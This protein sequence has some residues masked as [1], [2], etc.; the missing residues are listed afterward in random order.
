MLSPNL[1]VQRMLHYGEIREE[2]G[3][4][5]RAKLKRRENVMLN[6][7]IKRG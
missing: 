3:C 4:S 6:S 7:Q 5:A 2:G 1:R